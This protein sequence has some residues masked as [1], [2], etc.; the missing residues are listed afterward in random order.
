MRLPICLPVPSE[1]AY[2]LNGKNFSQVCMCVCV[3]RGG[4][5]GRVQISKLFYFSVCPFREDSKT[6]FDELASLERYPF[7]LI[8]CHFI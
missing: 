3:C 8:K 7:P 4:G 1:E 6:D 2:I 5:G